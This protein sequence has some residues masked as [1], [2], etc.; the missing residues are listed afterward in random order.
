MEMRIEV[1]LQTKQTISQ[2]QMQSLEILTMSMMELQ[3]F[4]QKEEIENPLIEH[5]EVSQGTEP[6][7]TYREVERFYSRNSDENEME[8]D[9]YESPSSLETVLRNSASFTIPSAT[10]R[11]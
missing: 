8:Y 10:S 1:S 7:V 5:N 3:E 2:V 6:I 4:L 11:K 9:P